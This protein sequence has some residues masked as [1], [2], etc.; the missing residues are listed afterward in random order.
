MQIQNNVPRVIAYASRSLT[1]C[2][3]NYGATELEAL[4]VIYAIEHFKPYI[5][6]RHFT[7]VTDHH[8]LCHLLKLKESMKDPK[9]RL[10]RWIMRLQPYD[11]EIRHIAGRIHTDVDPLSRNPVNPPNS[12]CDPLEI[13]RAFL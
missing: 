1:K 6:G 3:K 11:F 8:S 5:C 4:G 12:K 9:D 7:V 2:E 10:A 13:A